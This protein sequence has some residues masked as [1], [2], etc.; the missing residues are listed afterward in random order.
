[1]LEENRKSRLPVSLKIIGW[2]LV[3]LTLFKI[4]MTPFSWGH[5]EFSRNIQFSIQK[6]A[7]LTAAVL[8]LRGLK[9]GAYLYWLVVVIAAGLSYIFPPLVGGVEQSYS[10]SYI[11]MTL[12]VPIFISIFIIKNWSRLH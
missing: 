12:A 2:V 7:L 8:L 6:L 9:L 4:A 10:L 5:F 11:I 1:M 3:V